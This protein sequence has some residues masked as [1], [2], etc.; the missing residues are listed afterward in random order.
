LAL[1][2]GTVTFVFT[3][4]EG[5]TGLW[6]ADPDAMRVA[7]ERH[8]AIVHSAIE[9]HGGSVFATGGDGVAAVFARAGDAVAAA[10][11]AQR[12]LSAEAWPTLTPLRVRMGVHTG[13]ATERDGDYFG[14]VDRRRPWGPGA[15]IAGDGVGGARGPPGAGRAG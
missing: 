8:D 2:S 6:E 14:P 4:I 15:R 7:L 9:G 11:E 10:V 5:S 1:P 12:S 3:D 13:E